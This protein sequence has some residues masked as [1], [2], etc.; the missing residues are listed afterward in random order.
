MKQSSEKFMNEMLKDNIQ[1]AESIDED[2]K[3]AEKLEDM[4]NKK[5]DV[6][7]EKFQKDISSMMESKA[8][9]EVT[10]TESEENNESKGEETDE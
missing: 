3:N 2:L 8:G 7:Y 10:I 1:T 4:I 5:L 9:E 6:F